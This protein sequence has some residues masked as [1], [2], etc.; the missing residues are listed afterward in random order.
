MRGG[1]PAFS[2]R[3][4]GRMSARMRWAAPLSVMSA[5]ITAT[6]SLCATAASVAGS[7]ATIRQLGALVHQGLDDPETQASAAASHNNGLVLE[8]HRQAPV[9][10]SAPNLV[11]VFASRG[12]AEG[13]CM[14][15]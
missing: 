4:S 9:F 10:L 5:G 11:L 1:A 15:L 8:G 13:L 7:R 3:T 14:L 6:P 2:T 12:S